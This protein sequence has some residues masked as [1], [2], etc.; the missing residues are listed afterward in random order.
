MQDILEDPKAIRIT[1]CRNTRR[2]VEASLRS[3][4]AKARLL[5]RLK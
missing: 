4:R 2:W 3:T 1:S 5:A